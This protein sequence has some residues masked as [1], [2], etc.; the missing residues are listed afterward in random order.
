MFRQLQVYS[1]QH[2]FSFKRL[3]SDLMQ[4]NERMLQDFF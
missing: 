1:K 4:V 2:R 3:D